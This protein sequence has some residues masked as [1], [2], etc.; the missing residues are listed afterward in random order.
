MDNLEKLFYN[1]FKNDIYYLPCCGI[2]GTQ[3]PTYNEYIHICAKIFFNILDKHK[4]DYYVFAG[5][6]IGYV[7]NQKNIPWIDDYDIM[8]FEKDFQYLE[9][10]IFPILEKNGFDFFKPINELIKDGGYHILKKKIIEEEKI[11]YFQCD[12]FYSKVIKKKDIYIVQNIANWGLYNKNITYDM[13]YPPQRLMIDDLYLPFFNKVY[14][15]VKKEYSNV[16]DVCYIHIEHSPAIKIKGHFSKTYEKFYEYLEKAKKNT[17]EYVTKNKNYEYKNNITLNKQNFSN[18]LELLKFINENDVKKIYILNEKFLQNCLSIKFYFPEI[19]I[20]FYM[21]Q[22][23][24]NQNIVFFNY[25]DEVI[26]STNNNLINKYNDNDI[27][28]I[29]KPLFSKIKAIS[30]ELMIYFI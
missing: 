13:V 24:N 18:I 25:L 8:I 1:Y 11:S 30:L 26:F 23:I 15:D 17:L 21:L 7:R 22:E 14:D 6:S 19:T 27:I 29:K 16:F 20:I 12:I 10:T 9:E 3:I 5:T 28:Y 4:L 2:V